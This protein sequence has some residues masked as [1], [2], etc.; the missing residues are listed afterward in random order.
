[1]VT[2]AA[3]PGH[4]F[5]HTGPPLPSITIARTVTDKNLASRPVFHLQ[6]TLVE[7]SLEKG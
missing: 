7:Q 4:I 3:L 5:E 2:S 1:V 6:Q